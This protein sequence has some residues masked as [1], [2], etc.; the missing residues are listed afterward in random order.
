MGAALSDN[1]GTVFK[2]APNQDGSWTE[3]VLHSFNGS[4]GVVCRSRPHLRC[5]RKSLWYDP[6]MAA[7]LSFIRHG[8]QT[9]AESGDGSWTE[10][11]LH[12]F[13][14][15]DGAYPY[16]GLI[17]DAAGNLYGTTSVGAAPSF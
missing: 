13:N 9:G 8:F 17:F 16:A 10:S 15:S 5:G 14:R 12:S 1:Y 7:L 4:D 3:S 6:K 11:V 2:L